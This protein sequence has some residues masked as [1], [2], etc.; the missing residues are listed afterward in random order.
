MND[1]IKSAREIAMQ[2]IEQL[3]KV[4]E[5]E[6][7]EWK[8]VPEGEK[9]AARYLTQNI[10]LVS[11]VNKYEQ[12]VAKYVARGVAKVLINN[13]NL[14]KN[15]VLKKTTKKVMDGL[16]IVKQ[17]KISIENTYSKIRRLFS[18]YAEQG[19]QQRKQVYEGLKADFQARLQQAV[20]KQLGN[21]QTNIKLDVERQPQFQ[22]EWRRALAQLESQYSTLLN[23][24][25]QEL[26]SI[27]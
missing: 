25:K 17:D 18:H 10:D 5:E 27:K 21:L 22:E 15:D 3:G 4:T 8:Y 19:E 6:R 24:Y 26:A 9:L 13:I 16:K 7:Q 20:Q 1:E 2:K 12:N 14:P 23:E 11:E